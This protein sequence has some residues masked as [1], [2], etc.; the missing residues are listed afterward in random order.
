MGVGVGVCVC[1]CVCACVW[2]GVSGCVGVCDNEVTL[3][4]CVM[5]RGELF[6]E[7]GSVCVCVCV[8]MSVCV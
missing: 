6:M 7:R 2:V 4:V 8:R 5:T 1:V 3:C